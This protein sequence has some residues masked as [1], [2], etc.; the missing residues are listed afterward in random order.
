MFKHAYPYPAPTWIPRSSTVRAGPWPPPGSSRRFSS[1]SGGHGGP[2]STAN[3]GGWPGTPRRVLDENG[4]LAVGP[5]IAGTAPTFM[6]ATDNYLWV[7]TTGS[8]ERSDGVHAFTESLAKSGLGKALIDCGAHGLIFV[9]YAAAGNVTYIYGSTDEGDNWTE[10]LATHADAIDHFHSGA[11][12]SVTETLYILT[13]DDSVQS[14][15]L[16]CDDIDDLMLGDGNSVVDWRAVWGLEDAE[17]T[18]LDTDYIIGQGAAYRAVDFLISGGYGY[19]NTDDDTLANTG[20]GAWRV[21]LTTKVVERV[22][23]AGNDSPPGIGWYGIVAT[24]P[25]GSEQ[26]LLGWGSSTGDASDDYARLYAV[27]GGGTDLALL[28]RWR[29]ASDDTGNFGVLWT[30]AFGHLWAW[31][32]AGNIG[33]AGAAGIVGR[34]VDWANPASWHDDETLRL[35]IGLQPPPP[36]VLNPNPTFMPSDPDGLPCDPTSWT[37][38]NSQ[39]GT[40][41]VTAVHMTTDTDNSGTWV[42]GDEVTDNDGGTTWTGQIQSISTTSI[43]VLLDTGFEWADVTAGK[44]INNADRVDTDTIASVSAENHV[45]PGHLFSLRMVSASGVAS[46]YWDTVGLLHNAAFFFCLRVRV[47]LP[48]V[49]PDGQVT[50]F[51]VSTVGAAAT[52]SVL[53]PDAD[54]D[55]GWH[56]YLVQGVHQPGC[57]AFSASGG[58]FLKITL[59]S[60]E[61]AAATMHDIWISEATLSLGVLPV[62]KTLPAIESMS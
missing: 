34:V 27:V 12:D 14:S 55:G 42:A 41:S 26:V 5:T 45:E 15:I 6:H 25:D 37:V 28:R 53:V 38:A 19:W 61:G 24:M 29:D 59:Y 3:C 23:E 17:R 48:D 36:I 51:Y 43:Y 35:G 8:L 21:N 46:S 18:G 30:E 58:A 56:T 31:N 44:G 4:N 1:R 32:Q 49:T 62:G 20:R 60:N 52:F 10:L 22:G 54:W 16:V 47:Y 9:T 50:R 57:S 39:A 40:G 2:T 11:Y 7:K 33:T 13:G